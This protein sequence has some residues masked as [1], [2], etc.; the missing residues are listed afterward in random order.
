MAEF[1][2]CS[3]IY[4]KAQVYLQGVFMDLNLKG[5]SDN[6]NQQSRAQEGAGGGDQ[7]G[8]SRAQQWL[9]GPQGQDPMVLLAGGM[10]QLQQAMLKQMTTSKEEDKSPETVKPGVSQLPALPPVKAETSSIDIADWLEMLEAPMSDLSDGSAS[11][12]RQVSEQAAQAYRTWTDAGPMER[13]AVAPIRDLTLEDGRWQRVNSR[14]AS[15]IL[16]SLPENVRSEM[17]ARRLTGSTVSLLFRLMTLYQPG[18]EA[19]RTRILANLQSPPE[20]GEPQKVVEALRAWDRWLRR[21]KELSLATPDPTILSQG[22][23][24]MVRKVMEQNVDMG[25]RTNLV[26]STLQID[27]RPSYSSIDTYYKHLMAECEALAVAS[28]SLATTTSTATPIKPEPKIK[29]MRTDP[30]NGNNYPPPPPPRPSN[31]TPTAPTTEAQEGNQHQGEKKDTPC[32]Y[33]GRTF[34]GCARTSKCPFL[35]SWEGLE[36]EKASRCLACGGKHMVKDCQNKK[37][38]SPTSA[39][40]AKS[41]ATPRASPDG[42]SSTTN[43]TVRIDEKSQTEASSSTPSANS[44]ATTNEL[45]EVLADVGKML[46]AMNNVTSLRRAQLQ[47]DPLKK[48]IAAMAAQLDGMAENEEESD[49]PSGLLDSGASNPMRVATEAEYGGSVPVKVTLAGEEERVLRQN[50]QGTVLL[51]PEDGADSQP[52]VPLG[53]L[54]K[55]LGCSLQWRKDGFRLLHPERGHVKVRV[56]NNCPEVSAKEA[57]KLIKELE[58]NQLKKLNDQVC[59]L[60]ARLEMIQKQES[61]TWYELLRDFLEQGHQGLLHRAVLSCPFTKDLPADVK[62]MLVT[63]F[64][65]E[66]GEK[67]LKQLPINRRKRRSLLAS[68]DWVV[69]LYSGDTK[70]NNVF[71]KILSKGGKVVLEVDA[72]NSRMWDVNGATPIYKLLLWAASKGKISDIVGSPP[73]TTWTTS[74]SSLTARINQSRT[75]DHPYGVPGLPALL[76]QKL[77]G[78]SACVAKQLVLWMCAMMKGKRNVGFV[79]EFPADVEGDADMFSFWKTEM[80]KSFRSTAGMFTTSFNQGAVGHQATRPTTIGTTYPMLREL[81]GDFSEGNSSIPT[82]LLN[83]TSWRAWSTEL[84]TI[85]ARAILDYVPSPIVEEEESIKCG[86]RLSKLTKDQREAWKRHLLNDHQPYRA[87]CAV[88]LNAQATGYQHRRRKLPQLYALAVDLAGPYKVKGRDMDF[89]DYKYIMVAAYRCPKEYLDAKALKELEKEFSMEEYEPS[90]PE[91]DDPWEEEAEA[92]EAASGAE[93]EDKD[94][95]EGPVTLD[96]AVE[97]LKEAPESVTLYLTRPLRRRTK[98]EVLRASKEIL[99]QLKQTGLH[100]ATVHTDRAREFSSMMYKEWLADNGLRHSRTAG[101]DP[102]GNS[103]AELGVKWAKSRVRAL[104]KS[105]GAEAKDWPMAIQQATATAWAKAFPHSP[106]TRTPATPFGH[107]V[108]FRAK[109]YK[110]T[111]EKKFDPTGARWKKGWYRGPSY[112]V[113]RGHIILREDG[114]LTIA[115]SV[116]F[117]VVDPTKDLPDLLQPGITEDLLVEPEGTDVLLTKDKIADEV[118]FVAKMLLEKRAFDNKDVLYLFEKLEELG[119]TD[120]RIGKKSAMTS[121]FTGAYVHGGVAGL[122]NN[123]K[124]FPQATK[125]LVEY[126]KAKTSG[127]P[128]TA[129][130]IT[131][132]SS[133]GLHRDVHNS[134]CTRNTVIP[135]T[136]FEGGGVWVENT[137]APD[138]NKVMKEVPQKGNVAGDVLSFEDGNPVSFHPNRWHEVQPWKGDRVVILLYTPRAS[139]LTSE[140]LQGLEDLGF[141]LEPHALKEPEPEVQEESTDFLDEQD[142]GIEVKRAW[143]ATREGEDQAFVEVGDEDLFDGDNRQLP[144]TVPRL[145]SEVRVRLNKMIKKAEVQYTPNIEAILQDHMNNQKPLEVTHTV[146]LGE[147]RKALSSWASSAKKEYANLVENKKAFKPMKHKDL[148]KGCHVVPRKGVFTVKPDGGPEGFRRKTRFVACGNYLAE[149]ELTGAEF[150][151]YAAGLDATSLRTVLAYKTTKPTWGAGVTDIR[152]AFVLAPWIGGPVA[153]KPPALAVELGLAEED[154][155]WFVLQSIYGLRESPA[156]WAAYRDGQLKA[157]RWTAEVEG[158][159]VEV[160]L[161]QLASDNQVWRIVRAD[162]SD[163]DA[164][165]YLLVYIDDLMVVSTDNIM[166]SFF[167]W[168]SNMWE[169]DD[170]SILTKEQPLKFLGMELHSV[171]NGIEVA[172]EGFIRE[173]LRSHQHAGGKSR[174]QGPKELLIM[175][176]EEETKLLEAAPVNLEGKEQVL[177]EAQKRVGEMLWLSSR[178]RPDIQYATAVMSSRVTRCPEAVVTI[179]DRL[180]DYLNETI[181]DR[182]RFANDGGGDQELRTYTDSSFAPSSGRSHGSIA[183]FYGTCPLSWRSSRQPLIALSTAE[184]ELME[185]VEG[186]V[187]TYSTKCLIEELLGKQLPIRLHIDNSAAIS[188]MTTAA[189]SWRTR[190]LRLRANWVRE[191]INLRDIY[192]K[193]E[194]GETQR[195]DIGTKPFTKDRLAQLKELWDIRCRKNLKG[196]EI[197]AANVKPWLTKLL[198]MFQICGTAGLKEDIKTEV[199][200]DLYILLIVLAIAVIGLW[201]GLK[202]CCQPREVRI[203]ALRVKAAESEA[204]HKLTR[205]ELKELQ[206]LMT[207]NPQDLGEHQKVRLVELKDLFERTMPMNTSPVPTVR[208]EATASTPLGST[209]STSSTFNK[210]PKATK[211]STV[212]QGVQTDLPVFQRVEP[213]P[214][215]PMRVIAGPFHYV[216]GR[217]VIHVFDNCWGMRNAGRRRTLTLCRCCAENQGNR[218]Y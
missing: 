24:K 196:V 21:C 30:K 161:Q 99:L 7:Q 207:I 71:E 54:I 201:E 148:P 36:K 100:V 199:P 153:L 35:H 92:V 43:K 159:M 210:Q 13:L 41:A 173:L 88:C 125:Y 124:K 187:M 2:V 53:A 29:P 9:G 44:T 206:N 203:N 188:L 218:I 17:V 111:A 58:A 56:R 146:S 94:E 135:V 115:K 108:W 120:F 55:D 102:A 73:E 147:V 98:N 97:E 134:R 195:A 167:K 85:T 109:T 177:K 160:K 61:R 141:K 77:D 27:T 132:N 138:E 96:E 126:A 105:A 33:F 5:Q 65:V 28:A 48:R 38:S 72:A 83:R 110:G 23:S 214:P 149:G 202:H 123:V 49:G 52:I 101:G 82:S 157:A 217:D 81:D 34:R 197:R 10:A 45:K 18:G 169:C 129:L 121:W 103:T 136:K 93:E 19:E 181:S 166:V 182:L 31:S 193:H 128:F 130:G 4:L 179:G 174:T 190:H 106:T 90:E 117:N 151:V 66:G 118:E 198:M 158:V 87:D 1:E 143:L 8:S 119:D 40:T 64:E 133:L 180:L 189:G 37:G 208:E 163:E 164:L 63:S 162:D 12:W 175:S 6:G 89:D 86:A 183:I 209:S 68:R 172:Q 75:K 216:D 204:K 95:P 32:K 76:Q 116:K 26:R 62:A 47:D 211:K 60:T 145:D 114:G 191:K 11:W 192:V 170:L 59:S 152:Q 140:D 15:M 139:K 127:Q 113:N 137:D 212:D 3:A 67:Y 200:W 22:L 70:E 39:A 74:A 194:P 154:E 16:L 184:S 104:L 178:S 107:E 142:E 156:A 185:G 42:S 14:A 155:Y 131:R 213:Q 144:T 91:G 50:L 84:E 57:H 78:E 171:D 112:D 165:G 215:A 176:A 150:D 79:I 25:F 80:W 122:R 186:A 20:E 51:R 205:N 69:R 46:K 168:L